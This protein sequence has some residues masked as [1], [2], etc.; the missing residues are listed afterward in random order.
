M[1]RAVAR[2]GSPITQIQWRSS[3]PDWNGKPANTALIISCMSTDVDFMKTMG[4]KM[5]EGNDF[6]GMPIDSSSVILNSSCGSNEFEKS[7]WYGVKI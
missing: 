2:T 7:D 6:S 1:I 5:L 4:I 3:A